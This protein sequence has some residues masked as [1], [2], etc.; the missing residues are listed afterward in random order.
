[1]SKLTKFIKTPKRFFY[2]AWKKEFEPKRPVSKSTNLVAPKIGPSQLGASRPIQPA[3]KKLNKAIFNQIADFSHSYS[4]NSI[5]VDDEYIW[6]YLRS[7]LWVNINYFSVSGN[8]RYKTI[9]PFGIQVGHR[10]NLPY[11]KRKDLSE[12]YGIFEI[13]E[14]EEPKLQSEE[15]DFLFVT[16]LNAAEQVVLDNN[17]IYNRISDPLLEEAKKIGTAKRLEMVKVNTP[18]LKK[19]KRYLHKPLLIFSPNIN[20]SG[21]FEKLVL[22]RFFYR[23]F[24]NKIPSQIINEK[25]MHE[26]VDWEMHSRDYYIEILEKVQPKVIILNGFHYYAPLI[27]AADSLGIVTVDVQHGLQVGWNPLYNSWDEMPRKGYQALPDFFAVWGKKEYENIK[28]TF[29]G[30]KHEPIVLGNLW[31]QRQKH[32]QK[33]MSSKFRKKINKYKVKILLAMQNQGEIPDLFREIIEQ[34]ADDTIWIIRHHPKGN[35]FKPQNFSTKNKNNILLSDEIDAASWSQLFP[36]IDVT[37]S[38]GSA[39]ALEADYFGSYNVITSPEGRDNYQKEIDDGCFY[40]VEYDPDEFFDILNSLDLSD[41]TPKANAFEEVDVEKVLNVF[42]DK[43]H[44]NQD[45]KKSNAT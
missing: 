32:E 8:P 1:M 14:L 36:H 30:E 23:M 27:S 6:P 42:L 7:H 40:Y 15:I 13:E 33:N 12:K 10:N 26:L 29:E 28:D 43:Y 24:L 38:E 11:L 31:V 9:N 17:K 5:K 35:K 18:A 3:V 2:D 21:F 16:S 20:K 37:I 41:K 45:L 25:V 44:L 19:V 22:H 34:S 39:V 4:V